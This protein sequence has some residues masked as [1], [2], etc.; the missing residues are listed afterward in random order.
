MELVTKH[1]TKGTDKEAKTPSVWETE[2]GKEAYKLFFSKGCKS[3]E[4]KD[5]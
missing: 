2:E 4:K 1:S 3:K 5:K